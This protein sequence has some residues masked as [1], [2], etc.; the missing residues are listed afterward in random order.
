M[1][2][3]ATISRYLI[4]TIVLSCCVYLLGNGAVSLWDRD[5]P[6]YAQTS[7][8]MVETGDWILPMFLDEP[9]LK[10]PIL[11]Y[12]LQAASMNLFGDRAAEDDP[13]KEEFPRKYG[14]D[15][16]AARFPSAVGMTIVLILIAL[17]T[18]NFAGPR[19]AFWTTFIFATSAMTIVSAK[20]CLTDAVLLVFVLGSQ[21]CLYAVWHGYRKWWIF[22]A[23]GVLIGLAGLTKGPVVLAILGATAVAMWVMRRFAEGRATD[24]PSGEAPE[25]KSKIES[26]KSKIVALGR[27]ALVI[28]CASAILLPWLLA[29]ERRIP[30]YTW[31][32]IKTEVL[33]RAAKA[34][35]GHTGPPG[36]YLLTIWGTYFPWSLLLPL[37]LVYAW[38]HRRIPQIQFALAAVV[39]P[40]I[41]M[42]IV[43]TKLPHYLLPVYPFL[44][45]LTADALVRC[46]RKR[47]GDLHDR[48]WEIATLCWAILVTLLGIAPWISIFF[49]PIES[50]WTI[51]GLFLMTATA[52][53]CGFA[54]H[55]FFKHHQIERAARSMGIGF[56]AFV[57]CAYV[58]YL[59]SA[60]FLHLG[61]DVG[62]RLRLYAADA[63][64][65][66]LMVDFKEP[67]LAFYAGGKIREADE[68]FWLT[69]PPDQWPAWLVTTRDVWLRQPAEFR[70]RWSVIDSLRGVAYADGGRDVVVMILRKRR[71]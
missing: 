10:K 17:V 26:R 61:E 37:A 34:Q 33:D 59:P 43:K 71:D 68:G 49:Y 45:F 14:S 69:R 9:R 25:F 22:A 5:E 48:P 39:G 47:T 1:A 36:Y 38:R 44:A 7:R 6:R 8:Q 12:W 4:L 60:R 24:V 40:W 30:G 11:I 20:M 57:A 18:W 42:E 35:E 66:P 50:G 70:D 15:D 29:I 51:L 65:T 31:N 41:V 21:L 28:S 16:F 67:S 63:K 19:R 3:R 62:Y 32:T 64:S 27:I 58:V 23:W 52:V 54:T 13:L 53:A 55:R 56:I 2:E 46:V